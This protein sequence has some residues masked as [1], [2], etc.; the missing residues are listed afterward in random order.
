MEL[1]PVEKRGKW[2]ENVI[3]FDP[4]KPYTEYVKQLHGEV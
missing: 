4:D 2:H 1:P 3:F